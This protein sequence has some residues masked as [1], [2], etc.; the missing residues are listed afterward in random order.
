MGVKFR[1][2]NIIDHLTR[3]WCGGE[4]GSTYVKNFGADVSWRGVLCR[5][6]KSYWNGKWMNLALDRVQ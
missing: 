2:L 6:K 4:R 3:K 5:Q 1:K